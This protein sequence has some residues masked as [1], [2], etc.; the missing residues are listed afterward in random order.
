LPRFRA[1]PPPPKAAPGKRS[2][3][4]QPLRKRVTQ[5]PDGRYLIFYER[6]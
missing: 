3:Q 2:A 4:R 6:P 1:K 5:K